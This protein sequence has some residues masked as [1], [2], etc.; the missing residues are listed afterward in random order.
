MKVVIPYLCRS[1]NIR[2]TMKRISLLLCL[3][4][5]WM[6]G[7]AQYGTQFENRGFE[8]WANFGNNNSTIEPIHWHSTMSADGSYTGFL[9]QQMEPSNITR[10]GSSGEKSTRLW[11]NSVLGIIANG[12]MTNGRMHA[13]SLT[14]SGSNNYIYTLRSD[15]RFNTPITTTP[16][17]LTL[18]VCFRCSNPYQTAQV[19]AIVHGDADLKVKA[20]G[21]TDPENMRVA[22]AAMSFTRTSEAGVDYQWRRLSM[23]FI[24]NGSCDD[25]RY[26]LASMTTNSV[27]GEGATSDELFIDDVLLVYHPTLEILAL[28]QDHYD[29]GESLTVRFNLQGTMSPENLEGLHNE[30]IAQ[31]SNASGSFSNPTELGRMATNTSGSLEVTI[32]TATPYGTQYRIRVVSTNYPMISEDNG[33]DLTIGSNVEIN[34][35]LVE[36]EVA[37]IQV[38]DLSGRLV[39]TTRKLDLSSMNLTPG[40]YIAKC[41]TNNRQIIKKIVI[42]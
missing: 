32:P 23:P 38:F 29:I 3:C 36:D 13:G 39:L 2:I 10:P 37:T 18:W 33:T 1:N 41:Q 34:E 19:R 17:S 16:D 30:V 4:L 28:D 6:L 11:A 31:L 22:T 27:P 7:W 20:D 26:I 25:P 24:N 21:S 42:Q 8:E 15:D 12:N 5:G 14:P 9:S 40:I 35:S